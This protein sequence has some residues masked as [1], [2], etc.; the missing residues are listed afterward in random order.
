M[1]IYISIGI[2]ALLAFG[3]GVL[4]IPKASP[5]PVP[6]TVPATAVSNAPFSAIATTSNVTEKDGIQ[7]IAIT[8]KSGYFPDLTIAK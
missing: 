3:I 2:T 8:A 6:A 4:L 5:T 1:K 7:Y